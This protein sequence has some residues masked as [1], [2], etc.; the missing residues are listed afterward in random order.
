MKKAPILFVDLVYALQPSPKFRERDPE[1][2]T[3][4]SAELMRVLQAVP[5]T[6]LVLVEPTYPTLG[7]GKECLLELGYP[8]NVVDR[9]DD[10]VGKLTFMS[11][12]KHLNHLPSAGTLVEVHLERVMKRASGHTEGYALLVGH[13]HYLKYMERVTVELDS[14][15]LT[16]AAADRVIDILRNGVRYSTT[17]N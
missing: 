6:I 11:D 15:G 13:R 17:S 3:R 1:R 7:I 14:E 2:M 12:G 9:I 10:T 8:K 4:C 5:E 16:A